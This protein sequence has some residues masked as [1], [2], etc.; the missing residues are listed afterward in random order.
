MLY[1]TLSAPIS[2]QIEL[3]TKCSNNCPHC[4]NYQRQ[5]DDPDTTMSIDE[6]RVVFDALGKAKVF[7]AT[8][9]GG[10]PLLQPDLIVEAVKLCKDSDIAC[11]IN[12]N[13]TTISEE[14]IL[15]MKEAGPFAVLTSLASHEESTHDAM[16]GRQG[17]F[18]RTI[19]GIELL[20]RHSIRF[21]ANMVV[22]QMNAHQVYETGA[23]VHKL[24]A[25]SF[26][27]TKA[28]PPVGCK[29]YS[30]VQPTHDQIQTSLDNLLK[31][32]DD[33]GM[34][35]SVLE[36]YPHCFLKDM[37]KYAKFAQHKCSA[38]ITASAIGPDGQVRPCSHS[39][40]TYGS[41]FTEDLTAIY[42]RMTEWRTG[43]LL[44]EKCLTCAY[45]AACSGGC[46]CEAEYAGSISGM[47]PYA[48]D[49]SR[50]AQLSPLA[51]TGIDI[52]P[53]TRVLVNPHVRFRDEDFGCVLWKNNSVV[54]VDQ[55][56]GAL[57]RRLQE[58]EMTL[59]EATAVS[60]SDAE[61]IFTVLKGLVSK[62]MV[63]FT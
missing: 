25:R 26:S 16:M 45:F 18:T 5:D 28:S 4:Y 59:A 53:K 19:D 20:K 32:T 54:M 24:G 51:Q 40:R 17:A 48:T 37:S 49:P 42:A 36:C 47:D 39:N 3:T 15:R 21:S 60:G 50:V 34:P 29:D 43:E 41:I 46:R 31:L 10:E 12:T 58:T 35:V 2:V 23:F 57:L 56:A 14:L 30:S 1:R 61:Q 63:S 62:K 55:G 7:S 27:A 9:T 38:G 33:T 11:S 13:L 52:S 22:T 8:I 44:P 6:L